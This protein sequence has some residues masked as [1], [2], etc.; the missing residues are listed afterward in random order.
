MLNLKKVPFLLFELFAQMKSTLQDLEEARQ[1]YSSSKI[2]RRSLS[3]AEI[4]PM[5]NQTSKLNEIQ[6]S[7]KNSVRTG[8]V[9]VTMPC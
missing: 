8:F 6:G 2:P 4:P 3:F 9:F 1:K 7:E 5:K